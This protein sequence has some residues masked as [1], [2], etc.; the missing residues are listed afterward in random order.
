V[1]VLDQA[2]TARIWNRAAEDMWGLRQDEV[3]G[4]HLMSLDIGLPVDRLRTPLRAALHGD[5]TGEPLSVGARDRRG[6]SVTCQVTSVP[7]T[8]FDGDV[9]GAVLLMESVPAADGP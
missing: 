5:D 4:E 6:R 8:G 2:Q 3:C 7:L 1:V 9:R